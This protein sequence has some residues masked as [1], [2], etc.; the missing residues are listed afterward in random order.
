MLIWQ[1]NGIFARQEEGV[2]EKTKA[3]VGALNT[4]PANLSS[5]H[6]AGYRGRTLLKSL[7]PDTEVEQVH[8]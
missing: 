4:A 6:R 8:F 2:I 3:P 7:K 1:V 5:L